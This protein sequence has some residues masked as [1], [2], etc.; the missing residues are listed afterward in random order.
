MRSIS[1]TEML[2]ITTKRC[3]WCYKK[4][5]GLKQIEVIVPNRFGMR[6]HKEIFYVCSSEHERYFKKV[7]DYAKR[8]GFFFLVII[9]LS[10]VSVIAVSSLVCEEIVNY[11]VGSDI[12]LIGI[13]IIIFPFA[14]P[15]TVAILGVKKSI[16]LMRVVGIV[17]LILGLLIAVVF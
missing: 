9:G 11:V 13:L 10:T 12:S 7:A 6:A 5:E 17:L 2:S 8:F 1:A 3:V 14:T 15:E 4:N 16:I